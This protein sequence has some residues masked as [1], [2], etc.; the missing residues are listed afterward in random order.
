M[1]AR[2]IDM[3]N[4]TGM[5]SPYRDIGDGEFHRDIGDIGD[6]DILQG[7]RGYRGWD[8]L[9]GWSPYRALREGYRG[10]GVLSP[11]GGGMRKRI[12][13]EEQILFKGVHP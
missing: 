6:G 12:S 9:Q 11:P 10:W 7:W 4:F 13:H 1:A 2:M 5:T 8:T 3:R